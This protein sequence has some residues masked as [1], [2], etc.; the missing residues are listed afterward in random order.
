[1]DLPQCEL[2]EFQRRMSKVCSNFKTDRQLIEMDIDSVCKDVQDFQQMIIGYQSTGDE[3]VRNDEGCADSS[4]LTSNPKYT[5]PG[6][7]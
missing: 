5:P 7:K 2:F 3:R 1:M 4:S 6:C